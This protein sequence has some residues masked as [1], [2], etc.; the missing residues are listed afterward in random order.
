MARTQRRITVAP[1]IRREGNWLVADARIGS[2]RD[3]HQPRDSKKFPLGDKTKAVAWRLTR[4]AELLL[5]TP[6][7]PIRGSLGADIDLWVDQLPDGK[8]KRDTTSIMKHWAASPV[9]TKPRHDIARTEILSQLNRWADAGHAIN[10]RNKR[11]SRLRKLYEHYDGPETPNP[12]D[13]IFYTEEPTGV[14]RDIPVRIANVILQSIPDIGRADRGEPRPSFSKGKIGLRIMAY[15]GALPSSIS[16]IAPRDLDLK[17]GRVF[18][19]PRRKGKGSDA[20]WVDLLPPAVDAF[21]AFKDAHL[22]GYHFSPSSMRK[23]WHAAIE[24]ATDLCARHAALT[25]DDTWLEEIRNLPHGCT[26]R[27]LRHAF[28]SEIYARTGDIRAVKELLQHK[29]LDTTTRYTKGA[30]SSRVTA[31]ISTAAP[32]FTDVA[33]LPAAPNAR[34]K[35]ADTMIGAVR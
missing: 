8:Y 18:L 4:I 7:A 17:R 25:G 5:E 13:K 27:D 14:A 11:L 34:V 24:R 19:T 28:A 23:Q 15:T 6:N 30:V 31:A 35:R 22:F 16:R 32:A 2:S 21:R 20:A 26:P 3:P 29:S 9:A 33:T 1:G 12:T 10:T